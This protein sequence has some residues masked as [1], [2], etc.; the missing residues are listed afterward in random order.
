[1]ELQVG[2]RLL[3]EPA[4]SE[5]LERMKGPLTSLGFVI[6]RIKSFLFL[7][8][9]PG[10]GNEGMIRGASIYLSGVYGAEAGA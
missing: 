4:R 5:A 6:F 3:T 10:S 9:M 8:S 2:I 1:M 7:S